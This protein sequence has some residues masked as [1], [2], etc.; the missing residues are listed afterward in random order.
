MNKIEKEF[1]KGMQDEKDAAKCPKC[2]LTGCVSSVCEISALK[3]E[4]DGVMH[5]VDKWFIVPSN[6]NCVERASDAR[7]IALREIDRLQKLRCDQEDEIS[8]LK[9]RLTEAEEIISVS[10][11]MIKSIHAV[12]RGCGSITDLARLGGKYEALVKAYDTRVAKGG[13]E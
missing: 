6:G 5:S 13:G 10:F 1:W 11:Q 3:A 7:E 4:L 8:V 9:A 12:T 2:N